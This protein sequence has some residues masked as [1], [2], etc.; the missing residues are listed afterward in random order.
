LE[1]GKVEERN[2]REKLVE[3]TRDVFN[4]DRNLANEILCPLVLEALDGFLFI[5]NSDGLT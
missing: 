5:V 4:V 1:E 3:I 2:W